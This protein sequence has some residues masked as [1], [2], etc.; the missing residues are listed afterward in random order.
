VRVV[1]VEDEGLLTAA[2]VDALRGRG[3]RVLAHARDEPGALAA[4]GAHRPDLAV[5]D[6]RLPP[7]QTDEGI[8]VAEVLRRRYPAVGLLVLSSADAEPSHAQRLLGV[9]PAP[10]SIGYLLKERVGELTQL[11]EAMHRVAAGEVVIESELNQVLMERR[12]AGDPLGALTAH[13][14][15]ILAMVAEGRS[16]LGIAQR[17]GCRLNTVEKH[18]SVITGK[19]GLPTAHDPSRPG[20]NVRVLA[21]L[22]YLRR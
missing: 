16:N 3:V 20:V 11:I 1:L 14:R 5:L 15:R 9:E 4:V 21:A 18:L 13:E 2:L 17:I 12:R 8:R 19:L 7:D 6:I 10:R 22:A